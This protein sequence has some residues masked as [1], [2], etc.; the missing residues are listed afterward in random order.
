MR[1]S[2]GR[3]VR[4]SRGHE[5]RER[6]RRRRRLGLGATRARARPTTRAVGGGAGNGR[7]T[8]YYKEVAAG[9]R[10]APAEL[11]GGVMEDRQWM[12]VEGM[13]GE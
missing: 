5:R 11:E 6:R 2:G 8:Y 4:G 12:G 10:Q 9:K 7:L 13:A 3:S 1:K